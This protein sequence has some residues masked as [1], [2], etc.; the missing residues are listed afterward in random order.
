MA[1]GQ[2][3]DQEAQEADPGGLGRKPVVETQTALG[4]KENSYIFVRTWGSYAAH[5]KNPTTWW[6]EV[7]KNYRIYKKGQSQAITE[8][9]LPVFM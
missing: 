3:D 2:E 6:G 8:T 9:D 4:F 5:S 1:E 7:A